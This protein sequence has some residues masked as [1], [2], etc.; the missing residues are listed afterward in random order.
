MHTREDLSCTRG[1]ERWLIAQAKARQPS[2]VTYGLIWGM[3]AWVNNNTFYGPETLTYLM[4]WM[5]CIKGDGTL[6]D[7]LGLHNEAAQ[8]QPDFVLQL[9]ASLDAGGYGGTGIVVMDGGYDA[10][11]VALAQTNATYKSAVAAAGLH[12]PCDKPQPDVRN[13]GWAFWASEDFSRDPSW[14]DGATYWGKVRLLWHVKRPRVLPLIPPP[15][16][17]PFS[18]FEPK[19]RAHEHDRHNQL[20]ANLVSLHQSCLQRGGADEST[21]ALVRQL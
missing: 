12:Y 17:P 2:I 4:N 20:V 7:Y 21:H 16:L 15:S 10:D 3:P 6:V 8:P 5:D 19:L 9:R 18:G 11:E 14:N 1:Y 13:V